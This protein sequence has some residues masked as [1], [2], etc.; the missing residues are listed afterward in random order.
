MN[1]TT[2]VEA[3]WK[4]FVNSLP[5][6]AR[7]AHR[8]EVW[9]FCDNQR[10]ADELAQLVLQ[11]TKTATCGL[12]WSYE[13]EGEPVPRPGDYSV[14]IDWEGH[15]QCVIR[16]DEVKIQQFDQVDAAHAYDE[17]EG[18]RSYQYWHDVH[19]EVFSREC[20]AIGKSPHP[21]MIVV[22]ERFVRLYP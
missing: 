7:P 19:W 21:S 5:E 17:G 22:C 2:E 8:Y 16:T 10:A 20:Q 1:K 18:D 13:A 3:F 11:G 15:P 9:H 14:V 6:D 12:L 4:A